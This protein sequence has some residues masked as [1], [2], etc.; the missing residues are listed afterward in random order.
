MNHIKANWECLVLLYKAGREN[1]VGGINGMNIIMFYTFTLMLTVLSVAVSCFCGW[2]FP[3]IG[4]F[5]VSGLM[6]IDND[7]N[8]KKHYEEWKLFVVC[9][10]KRLEGG[11]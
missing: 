6:F 8:V 9:V 2:S 4:V 7:N 10:K 11:E 5:V 1:R 3:T